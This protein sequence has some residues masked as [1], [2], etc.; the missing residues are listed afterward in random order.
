MCFDFQYH[1]VTNISHSKKNLARY[2]HKYILV[3]MYSTCY[4]F[5][6]VTKLEFSRHNFETKYQ[7]P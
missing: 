2:V 4:S 3:F 7:I 6:I 5:Q 1:F